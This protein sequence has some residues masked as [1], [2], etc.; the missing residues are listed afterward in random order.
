[1]ENG[2]RK[3]QTRSKFLTQSIAP[4]RINQMKLTYIEPPKSTGKMSK[5]F[6][7]NVDNFG[8]NELTDIQV[9]ATNRRITEYTFDQF[10]PEDSPIKYK[11][12]SKDNLTSR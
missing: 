11:P 1:M 3:S 9:S 6:L 8:I 2:R 10:I 12:T 5:K 4:V 7:I